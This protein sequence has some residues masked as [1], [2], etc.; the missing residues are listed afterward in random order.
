MKTDQIIHSEAS[1]TKC[2]DVNFEQQLLANQL[3]SE[4]QKSTGRVSF[5]F[6]DAGVLAFARAMQL[7][8]LEESSK[9]QKGS[10]GIFPDNDGAYITKKEVMIGFNVSHTTL[11]KWQKSGYLVPI[12][13]GKR[14]YY[15]RSDIERLTK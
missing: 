15:K 7:V 12:K 4:V 8:A 3:V 5:T 13:I 6:T 14:V 2:M 10:G 9:S 11:W 1:Y